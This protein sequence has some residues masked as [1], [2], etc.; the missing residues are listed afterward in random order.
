MNRPLRNPELT[1]KERVAQKRQALTQELYTVFTRSYEM[2]RAW[3]VPQRKAF[4]KAFQLLN[5]RVDELNKQKPQESSFVI[6]CRGEVKDLVL[7]RVAELEGQ[8]NKH[9][10]KK[11]AKIHSHRN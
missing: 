2:D 1:K 11:T 5:K 6:G 9:D 10:G 4:E 3:G 7:K 8:V